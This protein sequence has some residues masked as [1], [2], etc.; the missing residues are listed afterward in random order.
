MM[1]ST[2]NTNQAL[3]SIRSESSDLK[4]N[5]Y[6]DRRLGT[7]SIDQ[8]RQSCH[9]DN[10]KRQQ[11]DQLSYKAGSK[12]KGQERE[13]GEADNEDNEQEHYIIAVNSLGPCDVICGRGRVAFNNIGNRRFRILI[14]MNV[15]RYN[16][17]EGR[18]GLFI[19]SLVCTFQNEIGARF[20]KLKDGQLIE[21]TERQIRQ[22]VGHALRDVL[23]FQEIKCQQQQQPH[24]HQQAESSNTRKM[25]STAK[26]KPRIIGPTTVMP[27]Y[28]TE[29]SSIRLCLKKLRMESDTIRFQTHALP[30]PLPP[31]TTACYSSH[32]A[33]RQDPSHALGCQDRA[34]NRSHGRTARS[35]R[36]GIF[37]ASQI[38]SQSRKMRKGI[39]I[40]LGLRSH[41]QS[42]AKTV[43]P[44]KR[45]NNTGRGMTTQIR[46]LRIIF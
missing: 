10:L 36:Q 3:R 29:L 11:H 20:F 44:T 18:K 5:D 7:S 21:L 37:H 2:N 45:L 38:A 12:I 35:Y 15:D 6:R 31:L 17:C 32:N 43:S 9:H 46:L 23:A 4:M 24:Q 42:H 8:Q 26:P 19:G 33:L 34:R 30:S 27:Q 1:T 13:I 40:V 25:T 16:D 39:G 41:R 22:K 14:I 28:Q